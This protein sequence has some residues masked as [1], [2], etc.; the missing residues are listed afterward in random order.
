MNDRERIAAEALT[1][2]GTP[3]HHEGDIKGPHG[4]VDCAMI[5]VRVFCDL[6]LLEPFDPRPYP[7]QWHLHRNDEKYLRWFTDRARQVD[8]PDIG[9]VALYRYGRTASHSGII[10]KPG[11]IVHAYKPESRVTFSE[12]RPFAPRLTSYWSVIK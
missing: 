5:L 1:W 3:Y 11:Y 8:V 4:G 12:M 10:V 6:G 7:M 9:D 2:I